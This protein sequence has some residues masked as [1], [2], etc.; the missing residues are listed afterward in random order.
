LDRAPT[1]ADCSVLAKDNI[2]A[3]TERKF[4]SC[5]K[6]DSTIVLG[7]LDEK[8]FADVQQF[9]RDRKVVG[10][11]AW[12]PELDEQ[13]YVIRNELVRA[14]GVIYS[15]TLRKVLDSNREKILATSTTE[16]AS[17]DP[18]N[19]Y[20]SYKARRAALEIAFDS[21]VGKAQKSP[22]SESVDSVRKLMNSADD[23]EVFRDYLL[24]DAVDSYYCNGETKAAFSGK[25][26]QTYGIFTRDFVKIDFS[27][28]PVAK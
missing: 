1:L 19:P 20:T 8:T 6:P 27:E 28:K 15:T 2:T 16:D 17:K 24:A 22:Q 11:T 10:F 23:D 12:G 26:G 18:L 5:L 13:S 25:F 21:D 9:Y 14:V 3:R 7:K 4:F